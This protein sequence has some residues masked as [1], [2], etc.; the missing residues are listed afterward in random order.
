MTSEIDVSAIVPVAQRMQD[1]AELAEEYI[2][3]LDAT[4]RS[5]EILFIIDGDKPAAFDSL[6]EMAES[7]KRIRLVKFAK[8]FGEAT[9]VSAGFRLS[10]GRVI[11]T[12]PAYYQVEPESITSL[13]DDLDNCDMAIAR[14]SPRSRKSTFEVF[15]R[16]LFHWLIKVSSGESFSDL[17]CAA[18]AMRREVLDETPLYGEQHS[19]LPILA[20]KQGFRVREV[21]L[22]QSTRDYFE[23]RYSAKSYLHR[24]LDIFSVVF[25]VRFTKKPIRFFGMIGS[26][27]FLFGGLV[28]TYI[29]IQRLFFGVGLADRPALLVSSLLTVL[30]LQIFALGLLGELIIFTHAREIKEYTI[31]K[32]VN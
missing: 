24:I 14:R 1:I 15:R 18:R 32:I 19:F 3:A 8:A 21:P 27:T 25:L 28:L 4:G 10:K 5:F 17:G 12:L 31:E 2:A 30:G 20:S 11:L 6:R 29:V 13:I 16:R 23:G 26:I 9:A 7:D 22:A